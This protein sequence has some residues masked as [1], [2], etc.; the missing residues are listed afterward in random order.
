MA[1]NN[2]TNNIN[3]LSNNLNMNN[4]NNNLSN[5]KNVK[6][7]NSKIE[8]PN[9]LNKS[10]KAAT[11]INI[12][13]EPTPTP[14][15]KSDPQFQ[16]TKQESGVYEVVSENYVLLVGVA[17]ALVICIIIYFFSESFRVDRSVSKMLVYQ[18]FQ[19]LMSLD[20]SKLG[21]NRLGNFHIASAYN[22]AHSGYQMYDYT[23]EKIVLAALQSGARYLEFNVFNSE[24]GES[25][26]PVV[27]MGYKTG[28]WKMMVK[29]TPLETIFEVIAKNAFTVFDS[30][31]GVFNPDDALFIGF[32]LNTNSNLSCLNLIAYLITT[33]FGDR[34]LNNMYSYQNNDHIADIK[35]TNIMGKVCFFASDGFQ[36]SG[37]EELIN[38][39]WDNTDNNPKH[40]MQRLNYSKLLE[41]DFDTNGLIEFNRTGLTI[42]VPH[43]EGDF[44]N[45][46]YDSTKAFELGCQFIA[47]EFQYIN[48]YMDMYITRYKNQSFIL[49]DSVLQ[50]GKTNL[51]KGNT[52]KNTSPSPQTTKQQSIKSSFSN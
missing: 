2:I 36:G 40:A 13:T 12:P 28:E 35:M 49:K 3:N 4:A 39:S 30:V 51:K 52:P 31:N 8:S 37:L 34:L 33:Y 47:M 24:Y 10:T 21:N 38:Y 15:P 29:D 1:N 42:I 14:T 43:G 17:S 25:A 19:R 7:I 26:Y 6:S 5:I 23:S 50:S 11:T 22:A 41:R 18:G 9:T 20:Y 32:N 45:T 46:N 27:S 16:T 44:F 48:S